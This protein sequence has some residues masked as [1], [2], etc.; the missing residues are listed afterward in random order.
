MCRLGVV[1]IGTRSVD[2]LVLHAWA[3]CLAASAILVLR[4]TD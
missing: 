3:G 4:P 1:A 2:L